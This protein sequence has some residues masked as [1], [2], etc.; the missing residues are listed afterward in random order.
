MP[1][2]RLPRY[3]LLLQDLLAHTP[4]THVDFQDLTKALDGMVAIAAEVN[5]KKKTSDNV[6]RS[7]HQHK[8]CTKKQAVIPAAWDSE[9]LFFSF[10]IKHR[11]SFATL[12][13]AFHWSI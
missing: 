10:V 2:Q 13:E 4:A 11:M 7:L 1:I 3:V 5:L 12:K 9:S 8:E 6:V